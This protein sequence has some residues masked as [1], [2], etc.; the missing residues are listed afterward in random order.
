MRTRCRLVRSR[1]RC[2]EA[3]PGFAVIELARS[4][5]APL[6]QGETGAARIMKKAA[7]Q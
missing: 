5:L 6:L 2:R 3:G 4:R 1:L 7:Q